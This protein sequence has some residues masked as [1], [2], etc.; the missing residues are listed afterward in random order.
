MNTG[1]EMYIAFVGYLQWLHVIFANPFV[2]WLGVLPM[3]HLFDTTMT[4][5]QERQKNPDARP[6]LVSHWFRGLEKAK[7][8]E[9][10]LFTRKPNF[11]TC[12]SY[13]SPL[14][15]VQYIDLILWIFRTLPRVLR[16]GQRRRRLRHRLRRPAELRLPPSAPP[17]RMEA[18]PGR[19]TRGTSAGSLRGRGGLVRRR[20]EA[21]VSTGLHQ[22]RHAGPRTHIRYIK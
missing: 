11:L 18:G 10:R 17:R 15:A 3:G 1:L 5:L 12:H 20:R 7:K 6:D 13:Q 21:A 16:H 9:S 19:D 2:T 22:G 8:D 4:A 14:Q